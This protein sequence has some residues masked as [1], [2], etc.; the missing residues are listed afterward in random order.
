MLIV[1]QSKKVLKVF[2]INEPSS[3]SSNPI[4]YGIFG[5]RHV[6]FL[7]NLGSNIFLVKF[8][9]QFFTRGQTWCLMSEREVLKTSEELEKV[10]E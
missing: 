4:G 7:I 1:S 5:L 10:L 6:E 9:R 2:V 3:R 8:K